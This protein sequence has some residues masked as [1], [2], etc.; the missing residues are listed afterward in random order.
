[1]FSTHTIVQG[2]PTHTR[3]RWLSGGPSG[4]RTDS[5]RT[6]IKVSKEKAPGVKRMVAITS[7]LI[8]LSARG[9]WRWALGCRPP[10]GSRSLV[11]AGR[12]G[13]LLAL[14]VLILAT[15]ILVSNHG[16]IPSQSTDC[17]RAAALTTEPTPTHRVTCAF[18]PWGHWE[19]EMTHSRPAAGLEELWEAR[20]WTPGSLLTW[21]NQSWTAQNQTLPEP[22]SSPGRGRAA[23]RTRAQGSRVGF[24]L[25]GQVLPGASLQHR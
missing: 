3:L 4:T 8:Q 21:E 18:H 25:D 12:A 2:S 7:H 10:P 16:N 24:H 22:A 23:Q 5:E 9:T 17:M 15:W 6:Q 20:P 19:C 14:P 11:G 1:M 13:S